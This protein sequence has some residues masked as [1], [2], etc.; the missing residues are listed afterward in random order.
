MI[1]ELQYDPYGTYA[2]LKYPELF[3]KYN[4]LQSTLERVKYDDIYDY[5]IARKENSR[6]LLDYINSYESANQNK[7]SSK[8]ILERL[9]WIKSQ[10]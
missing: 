6:H 1:S 2:C 9:T 10:S 7:K 8:K 5:V 4:V 3:D